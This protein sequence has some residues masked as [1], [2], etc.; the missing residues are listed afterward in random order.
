VWIPDDICV[1]EIQRRGPV[2]QKGGILKSMSKGKDVYNVHTWKQF[3]IFNAVAATFNDW[4]SAFQYLAALDHP[5][6]NQP[7]LDAEHD[8]A[9]ELAAS[10][11]EEYTDFCNGNCFCLVT[12]T[13]TIPANVEEDAE[14]A[15]DDHDVLPGYIGDDY[16]YDSLKEE[17]DSEKDSL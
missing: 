6:Y 1:E 14:I 3:G 2:Y 7:L 4:G 13:F 5:S 12:E 10:A 9:R 16:A 8:A 17:F 15:S 11:A